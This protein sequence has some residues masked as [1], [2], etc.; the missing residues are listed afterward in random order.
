MAHIVSSEILL[1]NNT[2]CY[3]VYR[4][5][6]SNQVFPHMSFLFHS[7]CCHRRLFEEKKTEYMFDSRPISV[8]FF[9]LDFLFYPNH[10]LCA[11]YSRST[12]IRTPDILDIEHFQVPV[13]NNKLSINFLLLFHLVQNTFFIATSR[14]GKVQ[15]RFKSTNANFESYRH[16]ILTHTSR[17]A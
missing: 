12:E 8:D 1:C 7:L 6:Y 15:N 3:G 16:R 5:H 4:C 2:S 17:N 11:V 14:N 10:F 13:P 9:P